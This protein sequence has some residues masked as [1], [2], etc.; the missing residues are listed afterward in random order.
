MDIF[1]MALLIHV[2]IK[3][4]TKAES[5]VFQLCKQSKKIKLQSFEIFFFFQLVLLYFVLTRTEK[6]LQFHVLTSFD[7][8]IT[9]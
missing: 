8:F 2:I 6:K 3:V 4:L 7:V 9:W 1:R 5:K